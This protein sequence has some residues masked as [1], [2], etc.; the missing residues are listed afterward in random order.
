MHKN[1]YKKLW[2]FYAGRKKNMYIYSK[3]A[4]CPSLGEKIME[5]TLFLEYN[6]RV[7]KNKKN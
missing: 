6:T 4:K 5:H 1:I 7:K 2:T 3:Q